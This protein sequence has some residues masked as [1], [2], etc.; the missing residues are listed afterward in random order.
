MSQSQPFFFGLALNDLVG[1]VSPHWHFDSTNSL[2]GIGPS[3]EHDFLPDR[4]VLGS[5]DEEGGDDEVCCNDGEE[6]DE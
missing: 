6:R 2:T 4:D 1:L 5:L 3:G